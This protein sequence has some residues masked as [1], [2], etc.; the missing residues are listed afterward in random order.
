MPP[1]RKLR[2]HGRWLNL[3][4]TTFEWKHALLRTEFGCNDVSS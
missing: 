2:I 3:H 4:A 1:E